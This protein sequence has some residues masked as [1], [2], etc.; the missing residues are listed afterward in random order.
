MGSSSFVGKLLL[1]KRCELFVLPVSLSSPASSLSLFSFG[2]EV[3]MT[4]KIHH[5]IVTC[6][7]NHNRVLKTLFLEKFFDLIKNF[8]FDYLSFNT[9]WINK[10]INKLYINKI[11][12]YIQY[13]RS[14]ISHKEMNLY[15]KINRK[16]K[17]FPFISE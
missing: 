2:T 1:A 9:K 3:Y 4:K 7:W 6:K 17:F 11:Y 5:V 13:H 14:D 16:K 15:K 8:R 10:K 12:F